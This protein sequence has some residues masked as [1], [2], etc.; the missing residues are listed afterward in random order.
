[1]CSTM[2]KNIYHRHITPWL[3]TFQEIPTTYMIQRDLI[4][5]IRK[6]KGWCNLLS[7]SIS[8]RKKFHQLKNMTNIL[9]IRKRMLN[10]T[11]SLIKK[12]QIEASKLNHQCHLIWILSIRNSKGNSI[13]ITR[14]TPLTQIKCSSIS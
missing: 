9:L 4:G 13:P 14:L 7:S 12:T 3:L 1:M 6:S 5:L 11:I 2:G 8:S 10:L